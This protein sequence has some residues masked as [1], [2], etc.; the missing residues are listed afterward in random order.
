[1]QAVYPCRIIAEEVGGYSVIFPDFGGATQGE[2]LFEALQMADDFAN[3]AVSSA[4]VDGEEI[5]E[6]SPLEKIEVKAGELLQLVCVDTEKYQKMHG[7][8]F[9]ERWF[10]PVTKKTFTLLKDDDV[11]AKPTAEKAARLAA[12]TGL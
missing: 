10:N 9:H 2:T 5:P 12:E 7:E 3:F 8:D 4:L 6:P 1:M 11:F